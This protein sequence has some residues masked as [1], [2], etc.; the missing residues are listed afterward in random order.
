MSDAAWPDTQH[1]VT[2]MAVDQRTAQALIVAMAFILPY[3]CGTLHRKHWDKKDAS[4]LM[5]SMM[6]YKPDKD[7]SVIHI[8]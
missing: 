1:S 4:S 5:L 3:E 2:E 7:D 6:G 8:A